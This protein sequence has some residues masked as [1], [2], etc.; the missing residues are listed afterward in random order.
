VASLRQPPGSPG[1][2]PGRA[3]LDAKIAD[4]GP[5]VPTLLAGLDWARA[6]VILAGHLPGRP[7]ASVSERASQGAA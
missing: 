5:D 3:D 2:P 7:A 1:R 4:C 6:A